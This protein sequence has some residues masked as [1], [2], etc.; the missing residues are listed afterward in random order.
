MLLHQLL[1]PTYK[2]E[3]INKTIRLYKRT[4]KK[5]VKNKLFKRIFIDA[6]KEKKVVAYQEVVLMDI[7]VYSSMINDIE[8]MENEIKKLTDEVEQ[9]KMDI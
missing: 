2:N 1:D 8:R 9:R 7:N 4:K 5:R 3:S 6:I